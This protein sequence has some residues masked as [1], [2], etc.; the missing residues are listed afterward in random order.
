MTGWTDHGYWRLVKELQAGRSVEAPTLRL[1][2]EL[3][4]DALPGLVRNRYR[5]PLSQAPDL[6]GTYDW[7]DPRIMPHPGPHQTPHIQVKLP[8]GDSSTN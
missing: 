6:R 1:A 4:R 3:R 8:D 7:H 2:A 5:G